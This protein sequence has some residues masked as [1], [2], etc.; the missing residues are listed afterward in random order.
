ML[1]D[2]S[3]L[4]RDFVIHITNVC[5]FYNNH[6]PLTLQRNALAWLVA[7]VSCRHWDLGSIPRSPTYFM[8]FL[9]T[10]FH[11]LHAPKSI[12]RPPTSACHALRITH[13]MAME[14]TP[15]YALVNQRTHK[16]E[17]QRRPCVLMGQIAPIHLLNG[18][19]T[20]YGLHLFFYLIFF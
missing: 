2:H 18:P 14:W 5:S 16:L 13:P 1:L 6:V 19:D 15:G 9:L 10:C 4:A 8:F 17:S 20:P 7:K 11:A 12:L 3:K